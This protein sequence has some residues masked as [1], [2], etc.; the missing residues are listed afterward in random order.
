MSKPE[1]L[2]TDM[3]RLLKKEDHYDWLPE[4]AAALQ[5]EMYRNT[6][7]T[8][9]SAVELSV[10]DRKPLEERL[11]KRWGE[12][13]VLYVVDSSLLTGLLIKFR[14]TVIDLTGRQAVSEF[15]QELS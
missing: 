14:D 13:R 10:S 9:V 1:E 7:I 8:V 4:I 2:A 12:H 15:K 5:K 11:L 3:I 6:D